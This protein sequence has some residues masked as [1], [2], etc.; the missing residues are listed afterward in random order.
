MRGHALQPR[1]AST[2]RSAR[3]GGQRYTTRRLSPGRASRLLHLLLLALVFTRT[4]VLGGTDRRVSLVMATI[5]YE[6]SYDM[7]LAGRYTW[8]LGLPTV[9]VL[10]GTTEGVMPEKDQ[11]QWLQ[12]VLNPGD[13]V[14]Y[15]MRC[16][17]PP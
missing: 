17:L 2:W 5:T 11:P 3:G 1:C 12:D 9:Y 6:K 14:W 13:V 7:L 16:A 10:N 8:R 15:V 4:G